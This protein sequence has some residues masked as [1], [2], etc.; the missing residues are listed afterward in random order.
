[1]PQLSEAFD[2]EQQTADQ[3]AQAEQKSQGM[4]DAKTAAEAEKRK[5]QADQIDA[6]TAI[7]EKHLTLPPE[8]HPMSAEDQAEP[9][10]V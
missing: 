9:A 4:E 3:E 1:M 10:A 2:E 6:E 8:L 5:A 7:L